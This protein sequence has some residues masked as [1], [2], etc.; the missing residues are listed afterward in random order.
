MASIKSSIQLFDGMSPALRS[1]NRALNVVINSFEAMQNMSSNV[2]DTSAIQQARQEL[3]RVEV[4]LEEVDQRIKNANQSLQDGGMMADNLGSKIKGIAGSLLGFATI[5]KSI[6]FVSGSMDLNS[7]QTNSENQLKVTLKNMGAVQGAYDDILAKASEIQKKGIYGDEAMIAGAAEFATYMKDADAIKL[8]MDTLGDYAVGM[9]GGGALDTQA[10]VQY[11][12]NLGKITNGAFDAMTKK[13][14]TFTEAQKAIINGTATQTQYVEV[15][16]EKYIDMTQDMRAAT[17]ISDVIGE[18]WSG[19]YEAM[20]NTPEGALISLKNAWGDI[21]EEIGARAYVGVMNFA[22]AIRDNLPEIRTMCI[23]F[24]NVASWIATQL[25][26]VVDKVVEVGT[27]INTHWSTILP[28]ISGIV[29]G[30]TIYK[31]ITIAQATA[32]FVATIAQQGFNTAL[33][34][35]PINWI[36]VGIIAIISIILG[37]CQVIAETTGVANSFFGVIAG[38]V[39]VAMVAIK[40]YA[41]LVCDYF[42]GILNGALA[43]CDNIKIAFS[44]SIDSVK[45]TFYGLLSVAMYVI[46]GICEYLN[47]LP[48]ISFDFSGIVNKADEYAQKANSAIDNQ[49]E[50]KSVTEAFK[51]GWNTFDAFQD[52]WAKDAFDKGAKWGDGVVDKIGGVFTG[53]DLLATNSFSFDDMSAYSAQTAENTGAMRDS[54]DVLEDSLEYMIDVAEREAINRYTT[55]EIKVDMTN[56]NSINSNMDIDGVVDALSNKVYEAMLVSAEGVHY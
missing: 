23:G 12:T 43:C 18:S 6:S 30:L 25:G 48:F 53:Q 11:A 26:H 55:A 20:S 56:N 46:S 8:M 47:K 37:L 27:F 32:T 13:G 17:V 19:L 35:C 10:I 5:R 50:Y 16:G 15:L 14:F 41:L 42:M 52:G 36:L 44:N 49:Q 24:A 54:M 33:S 40:E 3:A 22:N 29:A 38:G 34:A 31:A 28:I 21:R 9:S 39:N 45:A 1:M 4:T 51:K 2:I 7:I